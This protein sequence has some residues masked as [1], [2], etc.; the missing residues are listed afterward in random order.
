MK[1]MS[2]KQ[3]AIN[4]FLNHKKS[5]QNIKTKNDGYLWTTQ[6]TDLTS[7]YIGKGTSFYNSAF[8]FAFEKDYLNESGI[9]RANKL[10]DSCIEFIQN[11]GINEEFKGNFLS[12]MT[13]QAVLAL[14]FGIIGSVGV[15]GFFSGDWFA[16]NRIDK[17]K[18][19]LQYKIDSL[20]KVLS[21]SKSAIQYS[22][23]KND[24]TK[25]NN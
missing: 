7:K 20:N 8:Y 23:I 14:I 1:K 19:N 2:K 10:V 12:K 4:A 24:S 13:D 11:N 3:K 21:I 9:S 22:K 6:M 18:I 16:K 15:F 17:E 25:N 5:L